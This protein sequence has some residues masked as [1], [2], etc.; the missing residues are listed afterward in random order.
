[1][2]SRGDFGGGGGEGEAEDVHAVVYGDY[3][4]VLVLCEACLING[5]VRIE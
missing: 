5:S 1:M 4:D 2:C 3:D